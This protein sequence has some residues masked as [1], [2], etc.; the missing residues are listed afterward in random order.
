MFAA[1][2]IPYGVITQAKEESRAK[3]FDK[4]LKKP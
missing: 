4:F 3:S 1:V 2:S